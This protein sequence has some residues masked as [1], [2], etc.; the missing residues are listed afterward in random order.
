MAGKLK[1]ILQKERDKLIVKTTERI[2]D[3]INNISIS[4]IFDLVRDKAVLVADTA[5]KK[6]YGEVSKYFDSIKEDVDINVSALNGNQLGYKDDRTVKEQHIEENDLSEVESKKLTTKEVTVTK[7]KNVYKKKQRETKAEIQKEI[8]NINNELDKLKKTGSDEYEKLK[9]EYDRRKEELKLIGTDI[10]TY[11]HSAYSEAFVAYSAYKKYDE[12]YKDYEITEEILR[13]NEIKKKDPLAPLRHIPTSKDDAKKYFDIVI[14]FYADFDPRSSK[15]IAMCLMYKEVGLMQYEMAIA[16]I[17]KNT[18]WKAIRK[19]GKLLLEAL[20]PF[21]KVGFK[22][23]INS[24]LDSTDKCIEI[25]DNY[26]QNQ[27]NIEEHSKDELDN[28]LKALED[29]ENL[30]LNGPVMESDIM[31]YFEEH[32][33][34]LE[35]PS[36]EGDD[37]Y[38]IADNCCLVPPPEKELIIP[39]GYWAVVEMCRTITEYTW[40]IEPGD[41]VYQGLRIASFVNHEGLTIDVFSPVDRGIVIEHRL[42]NWNFNNRVIADYGNNTNQS[43]Y[44]QEVYKRFTDILININNIK[45][46]F[47]NMYGESIYPFIAYN[48]DYQYSEN[49]PNN[50]YRPLS[51][52]IYNNNIKRINKAKENFNKKQAKKDYADRI[53]K[54]NGDSDVLEMIK[55]DAESEINRFIFKELYNIVNPIFNFKVSKTKVTSRLG[56]LRNIGIGYYLDL[57]LLLNHIG[58]DNLLEG[59]SV[60]WL[61]KYYEILRGIINKRVML[62]INE[63]L[64]IRM[65]L[66]KYYKSTLRK[67]L[68]NHSIKHNKLLEFEQLKTKTNNSNFNFNTYL[69]EQ[70]H[71]DNFEAILDIKN[72]F[73]TIND[74]IDDIPEKTK[75][76]KV[77]LSNTEV[78]NLIKSECDIIRK[79]FK[80]A[81]NSYDTYII[82]ETE[83]LEELSKN[84]YEF[85]PEFDIETLSGNYRIYQ[86]NNSN[87]YKEDYELQDLSNKTIGNM[88]AEEV[89]NDELTPF[90]QVPLTSFK[91]WKRHFGLDTLLSLPY[92]VTW[93]IIPFGIRIK[94]PVIYIP[95]KVF[96]SHG[97]IFVLGIGFAGLGTYP[98]LLICNMN[99]AQSTLAVGLL[100]ALDAIKNKY[101]GI[102]DGAIAKGFGAIKK[103]VFSTLG[104]IADITNRI[105]DLDNVIEKNRVLIGQAETLVEELNQKMIN[106]EEVEKQLKQLENIENNLKLYDEQVRIKIK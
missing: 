57:I 93:F 68:S 92:L 95:I 22:A 52:T 6:V 47:Y 104:N 65:E 77:G 37:M 70:L 56:D 60:N 80:E 79:F 5:K 63:P 48:K 67:I 53:K 101:Y 76:A 24:I 89:F 100:T 74:I 21:I 35:T 38:T 86:V 46:L 43:E 73:T 19:Y 97:I 103:N 85:L 26:T 12:K 59:V 14:K 42:F 105:T 99:A 49:D 1:G 96:N 25:S 64:K 8:T 34:L 31:D 81:L 30:N 71:I 39:F 84:I 3:E 41:L 106:N 10:I 83:I 51:S 27:E 36:I 9:N 44:V 7:L 32:P 90:T 11:I 82:K 72:L 45:E 61:D 23:M 50:I 33:E 4:S 28:I 40:Y 87:R 102:I 13:V 94:L 15:L 62:E 91:Y 20:K 16:S 69:T 88:N 17:K 54:S 78:K 2:E 66:N 75:N 98:L 29:Y 55:N 58:T 18:G